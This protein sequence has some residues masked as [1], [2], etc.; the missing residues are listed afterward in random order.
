MDTDNV[1]LYI[2]WRQ[3]YSSLYGVPPRFH[4]RVYNPALVLVSAKCSSREGVSPS[5]LV[6]FASSLGGLLPVRDGNPTRDRPNNPTPLLFFSA[7]GGVVYV[8]P[9]RI[10]LQRSDDRRRSRLVE[11]SIRVFKFWRNRAPR[12]NV[13]SIPVVIHA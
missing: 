6:A 13:R 11:G 10:F 2:S 8:S 9:I 4:T 12:A 7:N 3:P 5:P 1:A